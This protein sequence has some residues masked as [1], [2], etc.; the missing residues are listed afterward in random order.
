MY[1]QNYCIGEGEAHE[2]SDLTK[3]MEELKKRLLV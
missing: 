2:F 1:P 3:T